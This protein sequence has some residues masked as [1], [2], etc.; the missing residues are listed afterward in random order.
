MAETIA[1]L[2]V[3]FVLI[4]IGIIVYG[5]YQRFSLKTTAEEVEESQMVDIAKNIPNLA[6][7]RCS[8]AAREVTNCIDVIKLESF[9]EFI[10]ESND[11][12]KIKHYKDL[13]GNSNLT[14]IEAYPNATS[15]PINFYDS[16][17]EREE[18]RTILVP[19]SLYFPEEDTYGIGTLSV[20][21]YTT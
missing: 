6:E 5:T 9:A 7:I 1:I 21:V 12:V 2:F 3:F 19:V 11:P 4:I 8:T 20:S 13:L 10:N 17:T 18:Y 14:V 15:E 16:Y